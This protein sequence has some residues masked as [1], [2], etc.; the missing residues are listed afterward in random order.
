MVPKH[1]PRMNRRRRMAKRRMHRQVQKIFIYDLSCLI[2]L[3]IAT[4][5]FNLFGKPAE[6]K[7]DTCMLD[8]RVHFVS[9]I[10]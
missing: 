10:K 8:T 9:S 2:L 4:A 3:L 1:P 6:K 7:D 5:S